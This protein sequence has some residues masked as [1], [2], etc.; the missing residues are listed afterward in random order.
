[1]LGLIG[2][3][4]M[5]SALIK[6]LVSQNIMDPHH[7]L[8]YDHMTEKTAALKEEW[9][10]SVA[11]DLIS[12]CKETRILFI[13]VKPQDMKELLLRLKPGITSEHLVVSLAA[14]LKISFYTD[15]LGSDIKIIRVMPNTPC[16]VGEGMIVLS[17]GEQ[18]AKEEEDKVKGLLEAL[19]VVLL[20]D[21]KH[22][23]AVT[24]LSGS[25]PAYVFLFLEALAD[26][27]VEMGLSRDVAF[28]LAAQ[29]LL[30]AARMA[31]K[32]NEHP[33]EL[34]NKVTSPGGTTSAG[35]LVME[36]GGVRS[37]VMKAVIE[38]TK[39]GKSLGH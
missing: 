13:A 6:G 32:S 34:K 14:G 25:G 21:E 5:G 15:L 36:E 2:C 18:V 9:K 35:L 11:S 31:L 37:A 27:G 12:L 8:V 22:L 29:T 23:D 20:L 26:G 38:A 7:I 3:G 24:G 19:G 1:M 16:L 17:R 28:L 10:V 30:G 4:T 33:A 39:R